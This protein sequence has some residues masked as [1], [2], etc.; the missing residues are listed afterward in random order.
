MLYRY[1]T[2]TTQ[3]LYCNAKIVPDD[4]EGCRDHMLQCDKHPAKGL[5]TALNQIL[6]VARSG[7]SYQDTVYKI[8]GIAED[9]LR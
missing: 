5:I 9:A 1:P 4:I 7:L 8:D 6:N 3:C 2:P